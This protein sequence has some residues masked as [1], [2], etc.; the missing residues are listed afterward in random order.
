M[1][2]VYAD[3]AL[4]LPSTSDR[5]SSPQF[6]AD[7][8]EWV[9]GAVGEPLSLEPV[10]NRPWSTVWR[11]EADSGLFFAK[12]NT[13]L[14]AFEARLLTLLGELAPAYVVPVTAADGDRDLLLT[15]DMG[16]VLGDTLAEADEDTL[17]PVIGRMLAEA[18]ELQRRVAAHADR[19]T[20]AGLVRLGPGDV[21]PYVQQR[22]DDF[23]SLPP[24]DPRALADGQAARLEASLPAV[25]AAVDEVAALGLPLTLQHNDLHTFNVFEVDG[26]MRF[27]DFG[28]ALLSEPL[29]ALMVPL[30]GIAQHLE[31]PADDQRLR[32]LAEPALEVWSDVAPL[33]QLRAALPAAL[34]LARLARCESWIRCGASMTEAELAE[35]GEAAAYWL[36]AVAD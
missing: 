35:Y 7:L 18:A 2:R 16:A 25:A 20:S 34:R 8:T 24:D 3:L 17:L 4:R 32:R 31:L 1:S 10:N 27:F 5:W 28:D 14:Q 19:L 6:R 36:A 30:G 29:G 15:P 33:T 26:R 11:V 9:A 13:P 23:A 12:Q 21:L 22:L